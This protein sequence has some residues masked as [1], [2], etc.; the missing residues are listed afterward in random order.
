MALHKCHNYRSF[1]VRCLSL[2]TI[3][4][5]MVILSVATF[6]GDELAS[7]SNSPKQVSPTVGPD[8]LADLETRVGRLESAIEKLLQRLEPT[9]KQTI[10]AASGPANSTKNVEANPG[11]II[12]PPDILL[13]DV[14][15]TVPNAPFKIRPLDVL[16]VELEGTGVGRETRGLFLVDPDGKISLGPSH[17]KVKVDG[18][19]VEAAEAAVTKHLKQMFADPQVSLSLNE[20]GGQQQVAGEHLVAPDGTVNLGTYGQVYVANMTIRQATTAIEKHLSQFLQ[21]PSV[22]VD[23]HGYNSKVYY[24]I[25]AGAGGQGDTIQRFILKGNETLLDAMA[26]ASASQGFTDPKIW[27]LRKSTEVVNTTWEKLLKNDDTAGFRLKSGDRVFIGEK[28]TNHD[29]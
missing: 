20:S 2:V 9:P 23:V 13:I 11:Y 28:G 8:G 10:G 4:V 12:E 26:E 21:D 27:V 22:A 25:R 7:G 19:S 1:A 18:L 29:T 5:A 14:L 17:G 15:R 24:I 3:A 6:A 16:N